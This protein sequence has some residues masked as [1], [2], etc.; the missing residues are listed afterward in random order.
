MVK[1]LSA[2]IQESRPVHT[3]IGSRPL[4]PVI[5]E[6]AFHLQRGQDADL[7]PAHFA[8]SGRLGVSGNKLS[9]RASEC[10]CFVACNVEVRN[11][12][13]ERNQRFRKRSASL[14]LPMRLLA[15]QSGQR[16]PGPAVSG[17]ARDARICTLYR[18]RA[19]RT[20]GGPTQTSWRSKII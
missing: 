4:W 7:E 16:L 13:L 6:P 3:P 10:C 12:R 9:C 20:I 15:A 8:V 1:R 2:P 14:M 11:R 17:N 18:S 5:S 19:L